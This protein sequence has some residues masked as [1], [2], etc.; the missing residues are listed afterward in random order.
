M[1]GEF[2]NFRKVA[3]RKLTMRDNAADLKRTRA[4]RR[5]FEGRVYRP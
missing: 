4:V 2:S 5:G 3:E 1:V